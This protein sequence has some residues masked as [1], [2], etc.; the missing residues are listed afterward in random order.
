M[1]FQK[2]NVD[3]IVNLFKTWLTAERAKSQAKVPTEHNLL[4]G[5]TA[6]WFNSE[7]V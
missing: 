3:L 4:F 5:I 7:F 2:Y 1:Q 6:A